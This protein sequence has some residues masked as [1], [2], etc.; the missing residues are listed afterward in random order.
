MPRWKDVI[1]GRGADSKSSRGE[2]VARK[3][4]REVA[5]G[6]LGKV[7]PKK[8]LVTLSFVLAA[9][10]AWKWWLSTGSDH[11]QLNEA[12]KVA[13]R[14]ES[15]LVSPKVT[16]HVSQPRHM[17]KRWAIVG[18]HTVR[19]EARQ[20]EGATWYVGC[21]PCFNAMTTIAV[22]DGQ[23]FTLNGIT[24]SWAKNYRA[25]IDGVAARVRNIRE[26]AEIAS[27]NTDF[28]K[29]AQLV[30]GCDAGGSSGI[31]RRLANAV[32]FGACLGQ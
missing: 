6:L 30:R 20:V 1:F 28:I 7:S 26:V 19:L 11:H 9:F 18:N 5:R 16:L 31:T 12:A 32:W 14:S 10:V 15:P 4:G 13:D 29:E 22:R 25:D 23:V 2:E 8:S 24:N 21:V 17:S 3:V 27:V